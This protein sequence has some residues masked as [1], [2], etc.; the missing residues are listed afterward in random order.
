M[1]NL[2]QILNKKETNTHE[3]IIRF[4]SAIGLLFISFLFANVQAKEGYIGLSQISIPQFMYGFIFSG[5]LFTI[6]QIMKYRSSQMYLFSQQVGMM[7]YCTL[8]P[9]YVISIFRYG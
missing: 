7:Q 2:R 5:L 3:S 9:A 6:S 4:Y 8:A 1:D